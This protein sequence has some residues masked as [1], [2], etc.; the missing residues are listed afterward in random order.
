MLTSPSPGVHCVKSLARSNEYRPLNILTGP[1]KSRANNQTR[2]RFVSCVLGY[3]EKEVGDRYRKGS[4]PL[5]YPGTRVVTQEKK[6][7]ERNKSQTKHGKIKTRGISFSQ[8]DW[9][10][11]PTEQIAWEIKASDFRVRLQ[12]W[13]ARAECMHGKH[14]GFL[15]QPRDAN[16]RFQVLGCLGIRPTLVEMSLI[17][18]VP[19][20]HLSLDLPTPDVV[21]MDLTCFS[22][23]LLTC[24]GIEKRDVTRSRRDV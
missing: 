14:F 8:H 23:R 19:Q 3:L 22:N 11:A 24:Y 10:A 16:F 15:F 7:R 6:I 18:P 17:S 4:L 20:I 21:W 5:L 13:R 1:Y 9:S 2:A 12:A